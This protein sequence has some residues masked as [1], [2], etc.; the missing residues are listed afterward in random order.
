ML[1]KQSNIKRG[2]SIRERIRELRVS[3]SAY[4]GSGQHLKRNTNE[5]KITYIILS[6]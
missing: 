6:L 4:E 5:K 2:G 3:E 1:G